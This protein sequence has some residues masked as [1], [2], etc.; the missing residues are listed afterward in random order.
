VKKL[1]NLAML[2]MMALVLSI[3]GHA[4]EVVI[5]DEMV[6][7]SIE[8]YGVNIYAE[9]QAAEE[10]RNEYKDYSMKEPEIKSGIK[11]AKRSVATRFV[12]FEDDMYR[13][14]C[15]AGFITT[16]YLNPDEEIIYTAGGDTARWV[17]DVGKTGSSEGERQI[18]AVKPFLAGIKTNLVVNTNKRSYNFFLHAAN[19]WYNPEVRFL[20][21]QDEKMKFQNKAATTL[22]QTT[23]VSLDKLNYEYKWN[24]KRI[25]F[26]PK[27]VFDD[28]E[29]TF[30][31]LREAVK[32]REI[33]VVYIKD[34]QTGN[35][36]IVNSRMNENTIVIDRLFDAA[37][38]KLGKKEV[39][40]KRKGAYTRRAD[41]ASRVRR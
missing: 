41:S 26:A 22:G 7:Q 20:Y 36:A 19:D 21:P 16:I 30:I 17:I 29:K 1:Q 35:L 32:T 25:F 10:L 3:P 4:S 13:I 15:R 27:Q 11:E 33:P 6:K 12:Y 18:V 8:K 31:I 23:K 40:I 28:G 5:T 37:T 9:Y 14:Y 39:V 2:F 34:E 24:N 38:L